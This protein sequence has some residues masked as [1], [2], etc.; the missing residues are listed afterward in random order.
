[1]HSF[2]IPVRAYLRSSAYNTVNYKER[3]GYQKADETG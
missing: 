3:D 2:R 1:V